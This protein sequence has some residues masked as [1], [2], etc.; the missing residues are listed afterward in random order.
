MYKNGVLII[1]LLKLTKCVFSLH[2][3]FT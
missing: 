1:K 2:Y 3:V